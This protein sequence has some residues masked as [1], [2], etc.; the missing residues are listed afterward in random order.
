MII[1]Q[2]TS[3]GV[4]APAALYEPPFS[5]LH[6]GGPEALFSGKDNVVDGIFEALDGLM[7]GAKEG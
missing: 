4:M 1:E 3:R 6:S 7:P 2:L 5:D